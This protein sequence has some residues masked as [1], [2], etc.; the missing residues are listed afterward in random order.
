[1]DN[2]AS[3]RNMC[4]VCLR[5]PDDLEEEFVKLN[6]QQIEKLKYIGDSNEIIGLYREP[7][8]LCEKCMMKLDFVHEFVEKF[9]SSKAK[10]KEY[11]GLF[12]SDTYQIVDL[13]P[14]ESDT[15]A[16]SDGE[17]STEHFS[18][19]V[20]VETPPTPPPQYES[21]YMTMAPYQY[22]YSNININAAPKIGPKSKMK[23]INSDHKI[24]PKSKMKK[25]NHMTST[26][27]PL[28]NDNR[29]Q[30]QKNHSPTMSTSHWDQ[31]NSASADTQCHLCGKEFSTRANMLRHVREH[32]GRRFVCQYEN[33]K[34]FFTQKSSLQVHLARHAGHKPFECEIC[35]K[36]FSQSKSLV[37]H[38]R[39]HTGESPYECD[40][41]Q[42]T[43]KQKSNLI[44]HFKSHRNQAPIRQKRFKCEKCAKLLASKQ[45]LI[46]HLVRHERIDDTMLTIHRIDPNMIRMQGM[47]ESMPSLQ[48]INDSMTFMQGMNNSMPSLQGM[49]DS[50]IAL[51]GANDSMTAMQGMNENMTPMHRIDENMTP[52]QCKVE[53]TAVHCKEENMTAMNR[54]DDNMIAMQAIKIEK[55]LVN[56]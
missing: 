40:Y 34:A 22:D 6:Q 45:S 8:P 53:G 39:I 9:N 27:N 26:T 52:L 19:M 38:I 32:E 11:V 20:K 44:R 28:S 4:R 1:M 43:F 2:F 49:N 42:K 23:N 25:F 55:N 13:N 54:M 29:S 46:R 41:C 18:A 56:C 15:F 7:L 50:M 10:I 35:G 24:G 33:C 31:G 14:G 12:G 17:D 16:N 47:N 3:I 37:F 51:Q 21:P 5:E 48:A 36:R 30:F